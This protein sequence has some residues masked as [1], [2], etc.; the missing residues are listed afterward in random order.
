MYKDGV[1]VA[2]EGAG[3]EATDDA[4]KGVVSVKCSAAG[5]VVTLV[6]APN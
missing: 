5:E 1:Q 3:V 2:V 4:E 6:I